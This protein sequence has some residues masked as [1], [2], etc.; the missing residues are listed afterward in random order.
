VRNSKSLSDRI[1]RRKFTKIAGAT[2]AS[3]AVP[4]ISLAQEAA[5]P[6]ADRQ[7]ALDHVVVMMFENRSFDHLLGRLY[8][9]GEVK[10]FEGVIGKDLKNPIPEWAEHGAERKFVSYGV[11][12]NMNTPSPDPGEEY[13]HI[14]TDLFGIQNPQ[15]RFKPLARMTPPYNAPDYPRQQPTMDGFVADYISAFT[16]EMRRQPTY[17][18]YSQIMTGYTPQQMPVLSTLARGFAAFDHWFCEVPSQTFTNRSFFHAATASGYVIN[19]PPA[20]AF[21]VHNTAETLFERLEAKGLTWRVY[22]DSPSP[23]S[24]TGIIHASRLRDRFATNFSTVA[25]FLED[26]KAGRL[27]TY[28]FIEPN[29][30]HG[31]NDMHPPV[32]ALMHGLPFD[33]PSSLLGGEALLASI[34]DAVRTSSSSSGSN[35]LNTLLLVAFDEAGGTY[36]HV[37]PPSAPPPDPKAPPGQMGFTFNRSGQR[38]PAIAISAWIPE[39]TVINDEYRH[40]SLIRTMRERWSLGPPLTARDA[41]ARDISP[42]LSLG[43]PR[44]PDQWPDVVA[45]PVPKFD[46]A[47]LPPDRPLSVLGMGILRAVLEF[48]KHLGAHV[49]TIAAD[50]RLTGA[51]ATDMM[52]AGAFDLFPGL[53]TKT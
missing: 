26:A 48:E 37:P 18:E 23:A 34:Y 38:V 45:R 5:K 20:D 51:Q 12:A 53:R 30:W 1:T 17:E 36:D 11:A 41:V 42:A 31:H 46:T 52:R 4:G 33:E 49:P 9:P 16:A 32:S 6:V 40:T 44:P 47:L 35:Y 10:S 27:P 29:M 43:Q 19:Y 50:E 13:P 25:D 21:P 24:F 28:S 22:C 3:A 14:N 39:H 15:N 2:A 7:K 8:E